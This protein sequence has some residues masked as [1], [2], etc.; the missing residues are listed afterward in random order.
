M[1]FSL[2]KMFVVPGLLIVRRVGPVFALACCAFVLYLEGISAGNVFF[3]ATPAVAAKRTPQAEARAFL[4][5]ER[6]KSKTY[7]LPPRGEK[8]AG[9]L[10]TL[11]RMSMTESCQISMF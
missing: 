6:L 4:H 7:V 3:S 1:F 5:K 2:L 10:L 9:C 11:M 8:R